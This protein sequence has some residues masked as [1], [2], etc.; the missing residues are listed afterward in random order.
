MQRAARASEFLE[1]GAH[2]PV[3]LQ[4]QFYEQ[5]LFNSLERP[6]GEQ[7]YWHVRVR[8][9]FVSAGGIYEAVAQGWENNGIS[10]K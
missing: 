1:A 5:L 8:N 6:S 2:W 9:A 4:M 7:L 3:I 10:K